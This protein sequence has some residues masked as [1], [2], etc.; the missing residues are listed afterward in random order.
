VD[1]SANAARLVDHVARRDGV[2]D[3]ED[4]VRRLVMS[5]CINEL[6]TGAAGDSSGA[7]I[8]QRALHSLIS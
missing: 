5:W 6:S 2:A 4:A 8:A 1:I 3:R 7:A